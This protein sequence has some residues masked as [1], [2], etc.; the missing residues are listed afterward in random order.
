MT[1]DPNS[2]NEPHRENWSPKT[3]KQLRSVYGTVNDF[4]PCPGHEKDSHGCINKEKIN[5]PDNLINRTLL[6][7]TFED[8]DANRFLDTSGNG[9]NITNSTADLNSGSIIGSA[10][11]YPTASEHSY[12]RRDVQELSLYTS[13]SFSVWSDHNPEGVRFFQTMIANGRFSGSVSADWQYFLGFIDF[14]GDVL[15]FVVYGPNAATADFVDLDPFTA[16]GWRCYQA[17]VDIE[18]AE[19]GVRMNAGPWVTTSLT[20]TPNIFPSPAEHWFKVGNQDTSD[21]NNFT[22]DH[23]GGQIDLVGVFN[24]RLTDEQFNTLYNSGNGLNYPFEV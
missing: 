18:E 16:T 11:N 9:N 10:G 2:I 5:D 17:Y 21:S 23:L 7:Y 14:A 6:F 1:P 12:I 20:V 4:P 3:I 8:R 22:G 19:I 13:K 24:G 15:R